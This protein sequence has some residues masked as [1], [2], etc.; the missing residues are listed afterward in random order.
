LFPIGSLGE[1]LIP[2]D[3]LFQLQLIFSLSKTYFIA[4]EIFVGS[5]ICN[6]PVHRQYWRV[7]YSEFEEES[8]K[9]YFSNSFHLDV[10]KWQCNISSEEHLSSPKTG[11]ASFTDLELFIFVKKF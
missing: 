10:G 8:N 6:L 7:L 4:A 11:K 1:I 2:T 9:K 5:N 3:P